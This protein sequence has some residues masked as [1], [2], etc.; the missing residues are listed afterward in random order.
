MTKEEAIVE[1]EKQLHSAVV[2]LDS[3]F[4]AH[5]NE[6]DRVY[7]KRKE[8]TEIAL[9]ALRAQQEAEKNDQ[10]REN[11]EDGIAGT[12]SIQADV[13]GDI[14]SQLRQ[15]ALRTPPICHKEIGNHGPVFCK[16]FEQFQL[17]MR[18]AAE[19]IERLRELGEEHYEQNH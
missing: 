1:F 3:G 9:S 16:P 10:L 6:S 17:L 13:E 14:A 18:T 5:P 7:R 4:G 12:M 15:M 8:M 2:V 11:R 19:E